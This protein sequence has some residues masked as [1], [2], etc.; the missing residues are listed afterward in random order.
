MFNLS[1]AGNIYTR[2]TNPTNAI[3]EERL[4]TLE[5]GIGAVV[6]ASGTSAV[7]TTLQVL[8]KQGD[9]IVASNSVYGG[10]YNLL[11]VTCQD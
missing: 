2:L 8:L 3:L 10:T 11:A 7:A 5:G 4:A 1:E 9:H 6:T